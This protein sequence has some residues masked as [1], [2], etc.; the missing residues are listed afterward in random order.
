MNTPVNREWTPSVEAFKVNRHMVTSNHDSQFT[1][2]LPL[3]VG[4]GPAVAGLAVN[5]WRLKQH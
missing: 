2:R 1:I 5:F 3:F 4:I